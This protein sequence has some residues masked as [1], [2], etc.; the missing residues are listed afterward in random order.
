MKITC[1]QRSKKFECHF[2]PF[3]L[4]IKANDGGPLNMNL[5]QHLTETRI[6]INFHSKPTQ[7]NF[8][9]LVL[10]PYVLLLLL[11]FGLLRKSISRMLFYKLSK[12]NYIF[13]SF[14]LVNAKNRSFYQL[15]LNS[16]Y[17][18]VNSNA[19]WQ[20]HCNHLFAN[21]ERI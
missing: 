18:L 5:E 14:L 16:A 20:E 9:Q 10:E 4:Q 8:R 19:K 15:L 7:L 2:K 1:Y 21:I 13:I 6:E 17:S 11:Q 12:L 3:D